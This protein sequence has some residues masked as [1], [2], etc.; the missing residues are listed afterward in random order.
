M[1]IYS[2]CKLDSSSV[3]K[4][5]FTVKSTYEVFMKS[6]ADIIYAGMETEPVTIVC[7]ACKAYS[8]PS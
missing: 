6:P 1:R 8:C 5:L 2:C 4:L 7:T 3:N